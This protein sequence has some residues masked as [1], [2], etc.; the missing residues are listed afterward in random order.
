MF[1]DNVG[2]SC[3]ALI[4]KTRGEVLL[5]LLVYTANTDIRRLGNHSRYAELP[6]IGLAH[7]IH[8]FLA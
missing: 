7:H 3:L 1:K 2:L 8:V 5:V 6:L 4:F